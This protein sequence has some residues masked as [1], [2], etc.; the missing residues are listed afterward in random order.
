MPDLPGQRREGG[1]AIIG[2]TGGLPLDLTGVSPEIVST[3]WGDAAIHV[4]K[5]AG[6]TID[7]L[8]RHGLDHATAPHRVNY[9]ANIAALALRGVEW[10]IAL[11]ACG[12]LAEHIRPGDAVV[13]DQF[14]DFTKQRVQTLFDEHPSPVVHVDVTYPYC[15]SIRRWLRDGCASAGVPFHSS[16]TYVGVDG[17]RYESAAEVR[18]FAQLGGDVIGMTGLPEVVLA[19]EVG[20]CYAC[21]SIVANN[22]AGLKR[23]ETIR[24]EDVAAL[25]AAAHSGLRPAFEH[26]L[27]R[28]SES[29][30]CPYCPRTP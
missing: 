11:N 9:R 27:M 2:G 1:I 12:G 14:L 29:P 22:A 7:V 6:R 25:M 20:I 17:P 24:H 15:S 10:I 21:L 30:P 28:L 13:V 5:L 4:V 8:L 26:A 16:G 3:P 23:D 18:M 19:R